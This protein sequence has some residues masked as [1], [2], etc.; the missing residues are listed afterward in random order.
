[1]KSILKYL[2]CLPLLALM[3][4]EKEEPTKGDEKASVAIEVMHQFGIED[5]QLGKFYSYGGANIKFST[6]QFYLGNPLI[7]DDAGNRTELSPHFTLVQPTT[8]K[9]DFEKINAG[10]AHMFQ[11]IVGV[12]STTNADVR[13]TDFA[14]D[15]HALAVKE[16]SMWWSVAAGYI[17]YKFEGE[18]DLDGDNVAD[19]NFQYHIGTN[20]FVIH[21]STLAH[22]DLEAGEEMEIHLEID[23][24]KIFTDL[25]LNTDL[26]A[27]TMNNMP[28]ATKIKSNFSSALNVETH[29]H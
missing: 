2:V 8:T 25:D 7:L 21:S 28:L 20:P 15:T 23:Y 11:F 18:I 24:A 27:K 9:I 26:D 5:F 14:D 16:N 17:F 22:S 10:H 1:M 13:P 4:C 3:A 19:K 29:A 12:D 6:A